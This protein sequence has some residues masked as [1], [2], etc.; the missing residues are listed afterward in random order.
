MG[1][2]CEKEWKRNGK[3]CRRNRGLVEEEGASD[4]DIEQKLLL[5]NDEISLRSH[6]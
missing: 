4:H 6:A 2:D 1:G 5:Y 3:W